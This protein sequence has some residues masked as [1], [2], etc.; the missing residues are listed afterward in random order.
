[1]E[2]QFAGTQG[3]GSI[4]LLAQGLRVP[5]E[6]AVGYGLYP[7]SEYWA[8]TDQLFTNDNNFSVWN[9]F[10]Q[11][12][13]ATYYGVSAYEN[14]PNI[15]AENLERV[16]SL[17]YEIKICIDNGSHCIMLAGF[18]KTN[19]ADKKFIIKDNYGPVGDACN[20]KLDY[21]PYSGIGRF[22]SAE[23]VT[24]VRQPQTWKEINIVGRWNLN[25]AGWTG[26]LDIYR[27]PGSMQFILAGDEAKRRNGG[28]ITDRR[29]GTFYDHT[30]NLYRVNGRVYNIGGSVEV[31]FYIDGNK[32]NLRW[33]ELSGRKF[34]YRLSADGNSMTGLHTDLDGRTYNGSATRVNLNP[35]PS[36]TE[37]IETITLSNITS[38]LCPV[39]AAGDR[40][41]NGG[42]LINVSILLQKTP[43]GNG[44]DAV[45]NYTAAE[46]AGDNTTATGTFRQRVYTALPGLRIVSIEPDYFQSKVTDFRGRGAGAEYGI[47]NEGR[48]EIPPVSGSSVREIVVVGDTGGNDVSEGGGCRCDTKIKSIK[49]NPVRIRVASK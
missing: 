9:R 46:T 5:K 19:A 49:F 12:A 18:D 22:I 1:R 39:L 48:V 33:D 28:E 8:I 2:N 16:L 34:R 37:R 20:S 41:F 38:E 15:T 6:S 36:S 47:C 30:G 10:P 26:I 45:I 29:L 40:E 3:G 7:V 31:E 27:M 25:Y 4:A 42:P 21:Y 13:T 24:D 43:D 17:G 11:I 35:P 23:Y 32:P 44:I 14:I